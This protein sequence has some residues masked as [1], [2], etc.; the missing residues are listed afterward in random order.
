[1]TITN[2]QIIAHSP[3]VNVVDVIDPI[4]GLIAGISERDIDF[5]TDYDPARYNSGYVSSTPDT[6]GAKQVGRVWW[7]LS[8]VKFLDPYTD[9]IGASQTRDLAEL[10]Y[11]ANNWAQIAPNT[12][13]DIYE[14][15]Q[16]SDDP[17]SYSG[18]GTVYVVPNGNPNIVDP[19]DPDAGY[20]WVEEIAYDPVSGLTT[21]TYYYWVSGL[22]TVPM[23]PFR[24]TDITTIA[25]GITNPSSLDLSFMS[26]INADALIVS[27]VIQ[28][29]NDVDSVMKVRLTLDTGNNPGTHDEW[30]LMRPTD[31]TSL[32]PDQL[33]FKLRDSLMGF[34]VLNNFSK[35]PDPSLAPTRGTGIGLLQNMFQVDDSDGTRS[36][37]MDARETFVESIN[38]ILAETAI[39]T[40]RQTYISTIERSTSIDPN[41]IWTQIDESYPYE[42][43]PTNEWDVMVYSLDQRNNLI[44]RSDFINATGIIRVLIDRR[45]NPSPYQG[46]SI[47]NYN[48]TIAAKYDGLSAILQNADIVF[49]LRTSYEWSVANE[50]ALDA[51]VNIPTPTINVGDR[52]LVEADNSGFWAIW[53]WEPGNSQANALGFVLWRV[54]TYR[55]TDFFSFVNWYAS[56]YSASNPPIVTYA[57][58]AARNST[59][60]TSPNNLFVVVSDDGTPDHSWIWTMFDGTTW[61]TVALENGTI[62]LSSSFYNPLL[63][64]HGI[65]SL[66]VTDIANRDGTWEIYILAQ[67]LRYGGLLLDSEINQ[68]WFDIV[69]FCHAQQADVAWAF[70]TSFMTIAGY[71]IPLEQT[72]YLI[73]DPTDDLIDYINEV[74]PYHVKIREYSTQYSLNMDDASGTI[75]DFDNP[76]YLDP[77]TNLYRPL[78]LVNDIAI[79]QTLPWSYWYD[80]YQSAPN[81]VR[82]FDI[83]I[84]FD[85]YDVDDSWDTSPWDSGPWD[86][87]DSPFTSV[88]VHTTVTTSL[89]VNSATIE[90][91]DIRFL[92]YVYGGL[93]PVSE[94]LPLTINIGTHSY[95]I[96][97]IVPDAVNVSTTQ[98]GV[99][100][101][102]TTV[103]GHIYMSDGVAGNVVEAVINMPSASSRIAQSYTPTA[104]MNPNDPDALMDRGMKSES[105][106]FVLTADAPSGATVLT[107]SD[108][109]GILVGQ[110]VLGP[111]ILQGTTVLAMDDTTVTLSGPTVGVIGAG[112]YVTIDLPDWVD[113]YELQNYTAP[114]SEFDMAPF[115]TDPLDI[116]TTIYDST[117]DGSTLASPAI[118]YSINPPLTSRPGGF[119]LRSPYYSANHP[120]ERIPFIGDDNI[121][122][123]VSADE[124]VGGPSQIIKVYDVS[125]Y[126]TATA[127][128]YYDLIAQ[129]SVAVMV[130]MDGVRGV[131]GTDYTLDYF[132]RTVTVNITGV[133]LVQIHVFGFGGTSVID[134][135]NYVSFSSNP[136][137]LD[138]AS[139][140]ANVAVVQDGVLLA[141]GYTVSGSEVTLASPPSSGTDVAVIVYDGGASTATTMVTQ[142]L[143]YLTPPEVILCSFTAAN[144]TLLQSYSNGSDISASFTKIS[145]INGE[146]ESDALVPASVGAIEY[147][148]TTVPA[149]SDYIV[150]FNVNLTSYGEVP[151]NSSIIYAV[152]RANGSN[153]GYQAAITSNGTDMFVQLM[154]MPSG[155]PTVVELGTLSSGF[156]TVIMTMVG[157]TISV[158][159]QRSEDGTWLTS[160]GSWISLP[161]TAIVITD[162][163]Y[164][165]IGHVLIGGTWEALSGNYFTM[166]QL[167]VLDFYAQSWTLSPRDSQ[168]VPEHAG[169]IVE[170]DGERLAP[171]M[172]WYGTFTIENPSMFL[173]VPPINTTTVTI[174]VNGELYGNSVPFAFNAG[175]FN[176]WIAGTVLTIMNL[177]SPNFLA[178][179]GGVLSQSGVATGTT[180]VEQLTGTTGGLGTYTVSISQTVGSS[181]QPVTILETYGDYPYGMIVPS[182]PPNRH[183]RTICVFRQFNGVA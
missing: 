154:V 65:N 36:G 55:T 101:T 32:P 11:R 52:V 100:G 13:V 7:N 138:M 113:G 127:T 120:E 31:E 97:A 166:T 169:T 95:Q 91:D 3:L 63:P 84:I 106:N 119:D 6:W 80:N 89:L 20:N 134:D 182:P 37:L 64:I 26:P 85:R 161:S 62:A 145:T 96:A 23:L 162:S 18:A 112:T 168:T 153:N 67:A 81:L 72:P 76:V 46:W 147:Q 25:A 107:F 17:G 24:N 172:T 53:K 173:P 114:V 99:S 178:V 140:T 73:P 79:L 125:A 47:W 177:E 60:G 181:I 157:S 170:V 77:S 1:V 5:R 142:T 19:T 183:H 38:N 33:W 29:L 75:T 40:Q 92:Q 30:I 42:P 150:T 175:P 12:S 69:N 126:T 117:Y 151:L 2:Q 152:G 90:V 61:N 146:I 94:T 160:V 105:L 8:T 144:N 74:K 159:V 164:T 131:L 43:A 22:T 141:S 128:L 50:T 14:W 54:Q 130:F 165:T 10:Y 48:P 109:T 104:N 122:I 110:P 49:T 149:I 179:N 68:N 34:N 116:V 102:L 44:A 180:I 133:N 129:S 16:S 28:F 86:A 174:Y 158:A 136:I 41:L 66:S 51:L 123:T 143:S 103:S 58:T 111:N 167:Q 137:T 88:Y 21:T 35:L 135:R 39:S 171:P 9:I 132:D 82:G 45:G 156:Y 176:G 163:T 118:D 59:E 124:D 83:T 121:Q 155:I 57:T 108:T 71:N 56:G 15:T 78:D 115:D 139:T 70:K 148:A 93:T 98:Y 27:G 87:T 4:S